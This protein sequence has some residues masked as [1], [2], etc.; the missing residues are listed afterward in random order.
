MGCNNIVDVLLSI[1]VIFTL[2]LWCITSFAESSHVLHARFE[3][4][5]PWEDDLYELFPLHHLDLPGKAEIYSRSCTVAP[6][7][8][9]DPYNLHHLFIAHVFLEFDL[10]YADITLSYLSQRHVLN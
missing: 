3:S 1:S 6:I 8:E 5:T 2:I 4:F 10:P 9:W 7:A